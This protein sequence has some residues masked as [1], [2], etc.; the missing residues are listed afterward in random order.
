[1]EMKRL[2]VVLSCLTVAWTHPEGV[3][4]EFPNICQT[5]TPSH[6]N[7][8]PNTDAAPFSI[9]FSATCY[10]AA[11]PINVTI[12]ATQ[13]TTLFI[14]F[15]VEA[16]KPG[17]NSF[18]YGIFD[19]NG[20]HQIKTLSCFN[21]EASAV[22]Q[23]NPGGMKT[24]SVRHAGHDHTEW[25][26]KTFKWTPPNNIA[27]DLQFVATVVQA[28][29]EFWVGIK[30]NTLRPCPKS[31]SKSSTVHPSTMVAALVATGAIWIHSLLTSIAV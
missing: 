27:D 19:S 4:L 2:V 1:M 23:Y 11:L 5:M 31:K 15:F 3:P 6:N 17:V 9:I 10:D 16:R 18:S 30:S 25:A 14:G 22:C 21:T 20:D 24:R 13:P 26:S 12:Q 8:A 7:T 28:Y 29:D